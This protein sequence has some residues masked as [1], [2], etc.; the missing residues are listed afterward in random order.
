[1]CAFTRTS[2]LAAL[3]LV[4]AP[5]LFAQTVV[6]PSGHWEG[7]VQAP[8]MEVKFAIDLTKNSKGELE[9]TFD[10]PGENL[11][12]LSLSNFAVEGQSI[13]FQIKGTAGERAFAGALAADGRSMSGDFTQGGYTMPFRLTRTG[14]ARSEPPVRNAAI[15]KDLE[16]TWNGTLEVKG[17]QR[18]LVL[19]LSNQPDSATGSI[20]NVEEGLEF[21]ITTITQ[22]AASLT[23]VLHAIGGSYS[24]TLNQDRTELAGT[25]TQ[26][27]AS[28]P[29]TF[30][31]AKP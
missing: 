23:L 13:R 24:G 20:L 5:S 22:S 27:P 10:Q 25:L 12:G 7:S 6:D 26:G 14:D 4:P 15:A 30:R 3:L 21:P 19:K 1:M 29:L 18:R 16:G 31:L 17:T 28:V 11:K 9:G 2:L 8:N